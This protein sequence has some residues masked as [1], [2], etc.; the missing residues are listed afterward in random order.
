VSD[1][2]A[3]D[4]L[5]GGLAAVLARCAML[6]A[7]QVEDTDDARLEVDG[8]VELVD[9]ETGLRKLVRADAGLAAL[10]ANERAAMAARL[11]RFCARAGAAHSTWDVRRPWREALIEHLA[12]ACQS[13]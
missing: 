4:E 10:A 2:L 8:D 11:R 3:E 12:R 7:L 9:V 6:Q 1:F 5:R 13:C